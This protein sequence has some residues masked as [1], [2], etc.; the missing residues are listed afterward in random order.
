VVINLLSNAI[1]FSPRGGVVEVAAHCFDSTAEV[2]V[3]DRGRGVP[4][5]AQQRIFERFAQ[6]DASD[7]K[8]KGG[9]GLGLAICLAI[10]EQHGGEIGVSSQEGLGSTFWFRLPRAIIPER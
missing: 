7:S 8:A 9:A 1:K 10:V 6:V 5:E 3:S 4:K 2:R